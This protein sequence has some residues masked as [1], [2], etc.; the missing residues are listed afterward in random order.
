M[1]RTKPD[2]DWI[3]AGLV[4]MFS[5]GLGV[6]LSDYDSRKV[7]RDEVNG[8]T[9]STCWTSDFGYETAVIDENGPHPVE[10]YKTKTAATKGHKVW[11]EK[12]K[13]LKH[14]TELGTGDGI[15]EDEV[16]TLT[17]GRGKHGS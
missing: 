3:K 15:I 17:R 4:G 11:L 13:T 7:A 6:D 16:I 14:I 8:L 10:R 9:I 5:M 2:G 1:K 12:A